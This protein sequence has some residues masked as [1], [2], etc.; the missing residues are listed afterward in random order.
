MLQWDQNRSNSKNRMVNPVKKVTI[1]LDDYLY[2]F[3][4]KVGENAG[5]Q[6]PEKVMADALFK[7]AGELALNAIHKKQS[8][9]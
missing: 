7:L 6:P 5:G 1:T 4:R 9:S 3:Y 2:E 8:S